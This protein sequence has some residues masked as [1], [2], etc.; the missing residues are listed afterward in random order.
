[1]FYIT[2]MIYTILKQM[3]QFLYHSCSTIEMVNIMKHGA[4]IPLFDDD[5]YVISLTRNKRLLYD[6]HCG[7][8]KAL[9]MFCVDKTILQYNTKVVPYNWF[10]TKYNTKH[11][12]IAPPHEVSFAL[13]HAYYKFET[14]ERIYK[15]IPITSRA[16]ISLQIDMAR[17]LLDSQTH[18]ELVEILDWLNSPFIATFCEINVVWV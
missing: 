13:D 12:Y 14:E 18:P 3:K 15:K 2:I 11:K 8:G 6:E 4:I 7:Y 9:F 10:D 1:M 5:E 17:F 16:L